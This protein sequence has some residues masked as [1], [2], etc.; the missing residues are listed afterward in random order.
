LSGGCSPEPRGIG[1]PT[2]IANGSVWGFTRETRAG[3]VPPSPPV[4]GRQAPA[5]GRR[6]ISSL[7]S[8]RRFRAQ[9]GVRRGSAGYVS[10]DPL[11]AVRRQLREQPRQRVDAGGLASAPRTERRVRVREEA[12]DLLRASAQGVHQLHLA[13]RPAHHSQ[14]LRTR[15]HER[16][17]GATP[18]CPA[19]CTTGIG[20]AA[21]PAPIR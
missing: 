5:T 19:S 1:P 6:R 7:G 12:L 15:H 21:R 8:A 4:C 9:G 14:Q 13:R 2:R 11:V 10:A 18:R 16:E 20:R 3:S 17:A